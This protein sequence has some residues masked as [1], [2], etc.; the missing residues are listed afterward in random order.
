MRQLIFVDTA[1]Q[2]RASL[3]TR[4]QDREL[5]VPRADLSAALVDAARAEA[6]FRF[7]DTIIGL[8]ADGHE[9]D[10][11]FERASPDRFD[12]VVGADGLHSKV[13]RI[14]FGPEADYVTHLGIYVATVRLE[15]PIEPADTVLMYNEAGAAAALHPGT[16]RPIAAFLFRSSAQ[17]HPH[18]AAAARRLMTAVYGDAGW[19]APELLGDYLAA[20]DTYFDSVSRVRLP[21]WSNG[22]ITLLGDDLRRDAGHGRRGRGRRDL[23]AGRRLER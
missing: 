19:R 4:S 21:S 2:R 20:T 18:D 13:R 14:V 6:D 15:E 8:H 22:L 23:R 3:A 12:L 11:T 16:D 10:V 9:V 7:D 5:E 17:V 1:G